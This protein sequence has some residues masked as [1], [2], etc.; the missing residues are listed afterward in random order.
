MLESL[1]VASEH[2]IGNILRL[3]QCI[4]NLEFSFACT[5]HI[6]NG[7]LARLEPS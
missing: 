5:R 4:T 2:S 7:G 1:D 6:E 3:S